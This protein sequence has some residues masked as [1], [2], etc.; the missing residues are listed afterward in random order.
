MKVEIVKELLEKHS[1]EEIIAY[2]NKVANGV[3]KNYQ[4]SLEAKQPEVLWGNLGDVVLLA[5][6]LK[7]MNKRN[8]DREAQKQ[9]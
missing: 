4:T 8:E 9:M 3:A 5:S 2:L 1:D 7:A 6:I